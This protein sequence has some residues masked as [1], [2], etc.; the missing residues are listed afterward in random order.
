MSTKETYFFQE[1]IRNYLNEKWSVAIQF[2]EDKNLIKQINAR[3]ELQRY[4]KTYVVLDENNT[5]DYC[6]PKQIEDLNKLLNIIEK[7]QDCKNSKIHYNYKLYLDYIYSYIVNCTIDNYESR[8]SNDIE[9]KIIN[10][11]NI[12]KR[13]RIFIK[14]ISLGFA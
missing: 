8:W 11:I 3:I 12:K 2:P 5:T 10:D 14:I 1:Y 9:N 13:K 6:I 4:I 7:I